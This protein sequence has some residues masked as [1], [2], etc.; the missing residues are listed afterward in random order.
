ML[1]CVFLFL[2]F[3]TRLSA[4][5]NT[6]ELSWFRPS[7]FLFPND[8]LRAY[9]KVAR[10]RSEFKA[11]VTLVGFFRDVIV[12]DAQSRYLQ[13]GKKM[14]KKMR[15]CCFVLFLFTGLYFIVVV[16]FL[17]PDC[18]ENSNCTVGFD[19]GAAAAGPDVMVPETKIEK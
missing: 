5:S 1:V 7:V 4:A 6:N 9:L 13:G 19:S 17:T 8:F 2:L 16:I 14:R 3:L 11:S 18:N 10:F 12:F 15:Y